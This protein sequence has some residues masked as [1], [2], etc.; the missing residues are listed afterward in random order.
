MSHW[1]S[2]NKAMYK[3]T[4][5][6]KVVPVVKLVFGTKREEQRYIFKFNYFHNLIRFIRT[7]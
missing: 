4:L 3:L 7:N 6:P 2:I 1:E 5:P